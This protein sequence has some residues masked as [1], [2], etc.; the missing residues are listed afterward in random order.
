MSLIRRVCAVTRAS[1]YVI[2]RSFD[3]NTASR[4]RARSI[5]RYDVTICDGDMFM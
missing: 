4:A 2:R 3:V 1:L 5:A